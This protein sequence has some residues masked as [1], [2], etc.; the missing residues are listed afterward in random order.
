LATGGYVAAPKPGE[1]PIILEGCRRWPTGM[2]TPAA[3]PDYV[4][5]QMRGYT[6]MTAEE[7]R[8]FLNAVNAVMGRSAS[9]H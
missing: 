7:R 4:T 2:G 6:E 1:Q 5:V 9:H 8:Q 3:L